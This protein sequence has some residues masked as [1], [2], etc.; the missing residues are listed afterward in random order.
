LLAAR[1]L[2][3]LPHGAFFGAGAVVASAQSPEGR[4]ARAIALMFTGLTVATIVGVPAAASLGNAVSWR[5]VF[6]LIAIVGLLAGLAVAALIPID[7]D[8]T[9]VHLRTELLAFTRPQVWLTLAIGTLGF[10]GVFATYAYV[11]PALTDLTGMGSLGL[12]AALALF[13][14]GTAVGNLL[15]GRLADRSV[16]SAIY[17][18]L[19]TLAVVLALFPITLHNKSAALATIGALGLASG[20]VIP[21]IQ[22]R[23]MRAASEQA[24]TMAAAS[25]QSC[26]NVA[27]AAGAALGGVLI[28]AGYGF[29]AP[30][31]VGALLAAAALGLAALAG[32][33]E[34]AAVA[35]D[36]SMHEH[37]DSQHSRV[38]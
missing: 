13:G 1:V 10:S 20:L 11:A 6:A 27:N 24:P 32:R 36:W 18:A 35:H 8:H 37:Q 21:P 5:L 25:V 9:A 17:L 38:A 12:A 29:A 33:L 28:S 34:R 15:G 2:T 19:G 22:V 16:Q 3:A 23:T 31:T 4:G 26:F 30:S 7:H 14:T